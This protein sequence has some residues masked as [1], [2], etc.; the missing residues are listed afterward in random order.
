MNGI[1][2]DPANMLDIESIR[3]DHHKGRLYNDD[4]DIYSKVGA[5]F[6]LL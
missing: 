3:R 6:Y 1:G 5:N 2:S 4:S